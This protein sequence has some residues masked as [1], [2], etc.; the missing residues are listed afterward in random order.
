MAD[1]GP[2]PPT[3]YVEYDPELRALYSEGAQNFFPEVAQLWYGLC[4]SMV[5]SMLVYGKSIGG[6]WGPIGGIT[7]GFD[8]LLD[9]FLSFVVGADKKRKKKK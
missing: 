8:N 7:L 6:Q 1:D 2:L 4:W 3:P 5:G 9:V